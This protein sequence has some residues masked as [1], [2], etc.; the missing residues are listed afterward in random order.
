MKN[1]ID[2]N[3]ATFSSRN[4][5]SKAT[6]ANNISH[7]QGYSSFDTHERVNFNQLS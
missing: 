1:K 7:G 3:R 4:W 2:Y 5:Q 6:S